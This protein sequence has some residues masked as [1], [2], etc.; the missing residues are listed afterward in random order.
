MC[1][2]L[3]TPNLDL[4]LPPWPRKSLCTEPGC[5]TLLLFQWGL[6]CDNQSLKPKGQAIFMAGILLGSLTWGFLSYW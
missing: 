1:S 4:P 5:H 2:R 6:V 3:E